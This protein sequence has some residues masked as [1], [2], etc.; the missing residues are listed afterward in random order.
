MV[1]TLRSTD[2]T[3]VPVSKVFCFLI[4]PVSGVLYAPNNTT[5]FQSCFLASFGHVS[6]KPLSLHVYDLGFNP[7]Y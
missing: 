2:E 1:A 7:G 3:D 5:V 6:G 4:K